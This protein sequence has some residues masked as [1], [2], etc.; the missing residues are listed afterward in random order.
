VT[1]MRHLR[2]VARPTA[3]AAVAALCL[4]L[5]VGPASAASVATW[6]KVAACE[7]S[8]DWGINTGTI[9]SGGLQ[10]SIDNWRHYGGTA[11]TPYPYQATKKQQILIAEKI[12]ADQ[13]A[14]AWTCAPGTGLST[15]T[16]DPYPTPSMTNLTSVG[17]QTGDGIPDIV[18][19]ERATGH[20]YR[21]AGPDFN[22]ATRVQIGTGWNI[23]DSITAV[24]DQN[25]D[26]T[27]DIVAVDPRGE[28]FRYSGP[29]YAVGSK[30]QVGTGWDVMA[31]LVEPG[32]ISGGAAPDLLAVDI[33]SGRLY[34]YAGPDFNGGAR[35]QIGVG[36]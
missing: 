20:L 16:A 11:Y 26:G 9:Y 17:D 32:D 6:D 8:G 2:T 15:D 33:V 13:G 4:A 14:G 25:G 36:W 23:Y 21:Y 35:V 12:L 22:G 34:R 7:S 30:V 10:I 18:T 5:T 19:V 28:L 27:T 29:G 1:R 24:G 31:D 3:L